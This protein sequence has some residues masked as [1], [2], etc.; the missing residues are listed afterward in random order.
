MRFV[1]PS[2][3][4][5]RSVGGKEGSFVNDTTSCGI[6][7]KCVGFGLRQ[8]TGIAKMESG[9]GT[10]VRERCVEGDDVALLRDLS[11][12]DSDAFGR[13]VEEDVQSALLCHLCDQRTNMSDADD[14][15]S[16]VDLEFVECFFDIVA[17][18]LRV[19]S[20]TGSP[21]D[22]VLFAPN[23]GDMVVADGSCADELDGTV[24]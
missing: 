20:R 6:D 17:D 7:N 2:I 12:W 24:L 10:I 9:I 14:A 21:A 13:V 18:G 5:K 11:E 1:F 3:Q 19:T 8:E 4:H 23:G 16:S 22:M 15:D